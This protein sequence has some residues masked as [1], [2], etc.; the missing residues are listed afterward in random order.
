MTALTDHMQ[1]A[2]EAISDSGGRAIPAGGGF[3]SGL[4]RQR[5][6]YQHPTRREPYALQTAT[7][8]ALTRRGILKRANK[9]A[10]RWCDTYLLTE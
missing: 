2:I 3:W 5:I 10:R 6:T 7:V 4:N 1:L 9:D 8:Y